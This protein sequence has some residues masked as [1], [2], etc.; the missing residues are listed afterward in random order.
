MRL[1]SGENAT[2]WTECMWPSRT[3]CTSPV[4]ESHIRTELSDEPETMRLPSGENATE[5]TESVW[6][7][8]TF[9]TSPVDESHIRTELSDEPETMRLPSG[10]NATAHTSLGNAIVITDVPRRE[11]L[12]KL[13]IPGKWL[14]HP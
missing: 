5:K 13:G 8:R 12:V 3:F 1:P 7:S 14:L 2:D 4:D 6:P 11:A 9:C 10:E